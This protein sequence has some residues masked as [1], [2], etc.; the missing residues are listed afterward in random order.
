MTGELFNLLKE[1]S[2]LSDLLQGEVEPNDAFTQ[3]ARHGIDER[4]ASGRT[5]LGPG[6]RA[7]RPG[8]ARRMPR[9]TPAAC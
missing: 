1:H 8:E 2:I 3:A 9:P 6:R 5:V 7:A 4:G